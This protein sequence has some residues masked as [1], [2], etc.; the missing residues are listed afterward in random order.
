MQPLLLRGRRRPTNAHPLLRSPFVIVCRASPA[1]SVSAASALYVLGGDVVV[2]ILGELQL[3]LG[4][5]GHAAEQV[6]YVFETVPLQ[7]TYGQ[8]RALTDA[9]RDDERLLLVEARR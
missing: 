6:G 7:Q 9:T 1:S 8:A 2:R 4:P 5:R 3:E